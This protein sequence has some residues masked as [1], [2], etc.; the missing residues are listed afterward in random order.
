MSL[1]KYLLP[2]LL[3]AKQRVT[4]LQHHNLASY[5]KLVES[6]RTLVSQ[7]NLLYS[8][9]GTLLNAPTLI[10]ERDSAKAEDRSEDA[11]EEKEPL[12]GDA[13]PEKLPR[14]PIT[15]DVQ[16]SLHRLTSAL[17]GYTARS[18]NKDETSQ[19]HLPEPSAAQSCLSSIESFSTYVTNESFYA[20]TPSYPASAYGY[21]F[22]ASTG[23]NARSGADKDMLAQVKNDIRS[24][25]GSFLTRRNF[26]TPKSDG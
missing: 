5:E 13:E 8:Q 20:S 18:S 9:T 24:L 1:Q 23:L 26:A 16:S 4:A 25:K 15:K 21:G 6:L 17:S 19:S 11:V 14:E 12:L 2:K 10:E 7:N 22:G 3:L